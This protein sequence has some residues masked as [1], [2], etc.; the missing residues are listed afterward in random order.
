MSKLQEILDN[1]PDME[2]VKADGFDEAVIGMTTDFK[3]VYCVGDMIQVLIDEGMELD[4]AIDHFEYNVVR[5]L[6][7]VE[8]APVL[9]YTDFF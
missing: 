3:L 8:N 5:S 2:F 4:D 1:Y 9:V 6:P 7:Y